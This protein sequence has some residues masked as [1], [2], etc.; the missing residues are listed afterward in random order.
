MRSA[1]SVVLWC[2]DL[3]IPV[4]DVRDTAE[5]HVLAMEAPEAAGERVVGG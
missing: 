2:P 5:L 4:A 1:L 3:D